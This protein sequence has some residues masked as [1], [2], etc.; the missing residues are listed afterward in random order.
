VT[1]DLRRLRAAELLAVPS[2]LLLGLGLFLPWYSFPSGRLDAWS[3]FTV[4]DFLIAPAALAALA[5]TWV[6]LTRAAPAVP[7]A[8]GVW[9]TVLGLVASVCVVLRLVFPPAGSIDRCAGVW[10]G[11]AGAVLVTVAGWLAIT[12]ERPARGVAVR[13]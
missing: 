11:L 12:D 3:A 4:V 10:V 7:V 9:T 13:P 1:F 5:L 8:M 2:G 6:T